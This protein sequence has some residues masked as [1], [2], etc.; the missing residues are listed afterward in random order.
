M[1]PRHG[2][3]RRGAGLKGHGLLAECRARLAQARESVR[4]P[5]DVYAHSK[6]IVM[7]K[8]ARRQVLGRKCWRVTEECDLEDEVERLRRSVVAAPLTTCIESTSK[9]CHGASM[10]P[11]NKG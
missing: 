5:I 11:Y 9:K 8:R 1:R 2:T 7:W 10:L 3:S 6:K 4:H